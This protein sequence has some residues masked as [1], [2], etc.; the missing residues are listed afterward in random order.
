MRADYGRLLAHDPAYAEKARR[1]SALARDI[2][3]VLLDEDLEKL[4][5]ERPAER[6]AVQTPCSLQHG[7]QRPDLINDILDKAGFK[8]TASCGSH[9]CCGS[10]GTYSL[11]QGKMSRRLRDDKLRALTADSPDLIAT[12]NVGCQLHLQAAAKVPVFHWIELLD[13]G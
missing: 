9:L 2:G 13:K 11:L 8:L 3:E 6:I 5:R 1:V 12:G 10:A 7:M 4:A